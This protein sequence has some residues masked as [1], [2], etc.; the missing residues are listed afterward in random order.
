MGLFHPNKWSYFTLLTPG[1][2]TKAFLVSWIFWII[3]GINFGHRILLAYPLGHAHPCFR[4]CLLTNSFGLQNFLNSVW[5]DRKRHGHLKLETEV[6]MSNLICQVWYV[7]FQN[8]WRY[9]CFFFREDQR[10][11]YGQCLKVIFTARKPCP[12]SEILKKT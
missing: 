6:N 11:N 5:S 10:P 4:F 8:P 7:I 12:F 9:M 1:F 2:L 3:N